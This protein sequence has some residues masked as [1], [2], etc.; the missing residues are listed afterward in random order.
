VRKE[1]WLVVIVSLSI[2]ALAIGLAGCESRYSGTLSGTVVGKALVKGR[3]PAWQ[4]EL[5]SGTVAYSSEEP[6]LQVGGSYE[7]EWTSASS[8]M[9]CPAYTLKPVEAP[10]EP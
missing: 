3:C 9:S 8:L 10:V 1:H 5:S 7:L 4:V 6:D 2:W